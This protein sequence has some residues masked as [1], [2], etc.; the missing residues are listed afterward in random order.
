MG[1]VEEKWLCLRSYEFP[2]GHLNS[3]AWQI[4]GKNVTFTWSSNDIVPLHVQKSKLSRFTSL[5]VL[6]GC[7]ATFCRSLLRNP[8]LDTLSDCPNMRMV[9]PIH[10]S[11]LAW[12]IIDVLT[13][14]Q[15]PLLLCGTFGNVGKKTCGGKTN[16]Q[17]FESWWWKPTCLIFFFWFLSGKPGAF[18]LSLSLSNLTKKYFFSSSSSSSSSTSFGKPAGIGINHCSG[19]P[20]E[21]KKNWLL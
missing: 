1:H 4:Y 3:Q 17:N 14:M 18:F 5:K 6:S 19:S 15:V 9:P 7:C 21:R 20:Q 10:D 8:C 13:L 16:F 2:T 11:G 12:L